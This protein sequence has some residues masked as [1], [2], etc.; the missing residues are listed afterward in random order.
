MQGAEAG[1]DALEALSAA[2]SA[3]SVLGSE[4]RLGLEAVELWWI[5]LPFRRPVATATTTYTKRELLLVRVAANLGADRL[6]GWGEC[7]ALGNPEY[8]EEDVASCFVTL[9]EVLVPNLVEEVDRATGLLPAPSR[10]GSVRAGAPR[11]SMAFA[12]LEMAVADAHLRAERCSLASLL[13]VEGQKIE[14]GAVVGAFPT[15]AELVDAVRTSVEAGYR[16]VKVKIAPGWDVEPL[17]A[18]T[19]AFPSLLLQ[20]DANGSY[21]EQDADHLKALDGF[22]LLCL[23]QPFAASKLEAH[24]RLAAQLT[25]PICL[26]ESL[27]SPDDVA[28]ALAARACSVVEVKPGRLGGIGAALEVVESCAADN[29]PL[30]MGGMFES[31]FARGVN[32]TV[33]AL[34]G[35][36]WPGDLSPA[37]TYLAADVVAPTDLTAPSTLPDVA[38]PTGPGMGPPP[39]P[40]GLE[41]SRLRRVVHPAC[42]R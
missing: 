10:L 31:G 12:A 14:A 17:E 30:W 34:P 11:S 23:E 5:E 16:R 41:R 35:F 3:W 27:D 22:E 6:D 39:D 32:T 24:S 1:S 8:V 13:G 42:G 19:T 9:E 15:T 28:E 26:D 38:V 2:R 37:G 20:V 25:T 33:A 21:S 4:T 18:I 40:A 36:S 29:V 7:A